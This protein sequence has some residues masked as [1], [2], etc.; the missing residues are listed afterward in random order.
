MI[1]M[2]S[3]L[4]LDRG[5]RIQFYSV[6]YTLC[7]YIKVCDRVSYS[8][9]RPSDVREKVMRRSVDL[10]S[11]WITC[12]YTVDLYELKAVT[13]TLIDFLQEEVNI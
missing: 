2:I 9:K 5:Y 4:W 3:S 7:K 12:Y 6:Y 8:M 13:S 1:V 10:L 11:F